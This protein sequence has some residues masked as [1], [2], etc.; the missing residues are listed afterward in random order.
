MSDVILVSVPYAALQHPS[1]AL[2]CLQ[3]ILKRRGIDTRTF[4]ANLK[5]AQRIGIGNYVWFSAYARP[6]LLG[7][8]TFAQAA[9]PEFAPDL[10]TYV[11]TLG[12]PEAED[13]IRRVRIEAASF[14]DEM[15]EAIVE[16]AP[17]I[18][19]CSSTFQQ[20]CASLALLRR[21]KQYAPDIVTVMGGANCEAEMGRALHT[22]FPW[23]DYV[24]SGDADDVFPEFCERI[25]RDD[26]AGFERNEL[27]SRY[28]FTPSTRPLGLM[29]Q[30]VS[31]T[32]QNMNTLPLPDYDDYFAALEETKIAP[33]ATPGLLAQT[34]RGCWWGEKHPCTFCG[35]N[36][37]CMSFRSMSAE[38]AEKLICG[39]A[40]R[41]A[42]DGVELIDN[43]L[44]PSY[45]KTVLP[46][47]ARKNKRLRMACEVKA[48]L[49][50]DQVRLLADSGMVWVQPGI[51]S[52]HDESL[53]LIDKGTTRCQN[54]QLL[55]WGREFGVHLTWN[56]LM[57]IPGERPEWYAEVAEIIPLLVH[58]KAPNGPGGRLSFDRFSVYH[59]HPDHFKLTL[60]P[61]W[62]YTYVYPLP[63]RELMDLAYHF[64]DVG[65]GAHER[66]FPEQDLLKKRLDEWCELQPEPSGHENREDLPPLPRLDVSLV[67]DG[68][69][70]EDT[71]PCALAPRYE[72]SGLTAYLYNACD[73][74]RS[75]EKLLTEARA[76][77]FAELTAAA[78]D[79]EL[80]TFVEQ[81][82]MVP[83]SGRFL[84]L[85]VRA[86]YPP[87]R[88]LDQHPDGQVYLHPVRKPQTG[89][90]QTVEEVYMLQ[91]G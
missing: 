69:L 32:V 37:G 14:M 47:L 27:L 9:F 10:H 56:Y 49:T 8:F 3:A 64:D 88:P 66:R 31:A 22:N 23:L 26:V 46:S 11:S 65:P 40:D 73:R 55:K 82:L 1:P 81:R 53:K 51:E 70:V 52:L 57:G 4:H 63:L 78:L 68:L 90:E 84:S 25:L 38:S 12:V 35:L 72:F 44:E 18:V 41:H 76:D 7:E 16:E 60:R 50:R 79:R 75:A 24:V 39:L 85:A 6:L 28:V 91:T 42:I 80:A 83:A 62:G 59:T 36:G 5:F 21:I 34:A 45:F 33:F 17:R 77:G 61:A 74:G 15:A 48:N 20:N 86:P 43:I 54:L 67:G 2:G 71:R 58:L 13:A 30:A 29:R 19:G 89:H 87:W